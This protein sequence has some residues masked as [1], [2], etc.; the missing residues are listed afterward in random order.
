MHML[1][2]SADLSLFRYANVREMQQKLETSEETKRS[3]GQTQKWKFE[4]GDSRGTSPL[5]LFL[6]DVRTKLNPDI[7]GGEVAMPKSLGN[8]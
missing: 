7:N 8:G 1:A 3:S 2:G 4:Q 5:P 6:I